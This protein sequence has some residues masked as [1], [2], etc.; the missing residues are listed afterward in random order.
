MSDKI[1]VE[2]AHSSAAPDNTSLMSW[3][4]DEYSDKVHAT[5][6][7]LIGRLAAVWMA[8]GAS[9][10]GSK[11]IPQ[12]ATGSF[13]LPF[14]VADFTAIRASEQA[15]P[16]TP[17]EIATYA[18]PIALGGA[19]ISEQLATVGTSVCL[20]RTAGQAPGRHGVGR[21]Y[22]PY[23]DSF[24]LTNQGH[25]DVASCAWTTSVLNYFFKHGPIPPV[26]PG[27]PTPMSIAPHPFD[28][29][30]QMQL[31][32]PGVADYT[33]DSYATRTKPTVLRSRQR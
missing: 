26:G 20:S 7:R 1:I 2:I 13:P 17:A 23:I 19:A 14:P 24:R 16:V 29:T 25:F 6:L 5:I 15:A 30:L 10:V 21:T 12:G 3:S 9:I 22:L 27:L 4:V 32:T 28:W 18:F 33:I 8:P 11:V 31:T